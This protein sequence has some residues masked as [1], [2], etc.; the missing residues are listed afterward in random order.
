MQKPLLYVS[1]IVLVFLFYTWNRNRVW[2]SDFSLYQ[3]DAQYSEKSSGVN[4]LLGNKYFEMLLSGD[5]KYSQQELIDKALKHF[6]LAIRD[7]SAMYSAYNNAGV[8]YFSYLNKLDIANGYFMGAIHSKPDYSQ[9]YEN[10]GNYYKKKGDF[11]QAFKNYRIATLQNPYQYKS[12][13]ELISMLIEKNNFV[14]AYP[15]IKEA[16]ENFP[17]DYFITSQY[18][19]YYLMTGDTTNGMYKLEEAF[20]MYPNKKLAKYLF[21]K[22]NELKQMDKAEYYRNQYAILP[23]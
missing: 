23:Q 1:G 13:T 11:M 22:C 4:N 12:Y 3:H 5:S 9:A 7:D 14:S 15:I 2:E 10:I 19:N 20:K 17:K 18:G 6:N 16:D 8:I 21:G